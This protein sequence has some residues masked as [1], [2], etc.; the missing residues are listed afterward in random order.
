MENTSLHGGHISH[1]FTPTYPDSAGQMDETTAHQEF[2]LRRSPKFRRGRS[3]RSIGGI[4]RPFV[5]FLQEFHSFL[6]ETG[7]RIA[8]V[9][10][11][12]GCTFPG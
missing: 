12:K 10:R 2:M 8:C 7:A 4:G 3:R 1:G 6:T 9:R 11:P 5:V